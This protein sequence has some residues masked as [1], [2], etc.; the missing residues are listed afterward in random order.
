M[1]SMI[2]ILGFAWRSQLDAHRAEQAR[3]FAEQETQ[4]AR[5]VQSF[6]TD[7]FARQRP[8]VAQGR[9]ISAKDLLDDAEQQLSK[10]GAGTS[11]EV[12]AELLE[13]LANLRYDLN[14][15]DSALRHNEA[16]IAL[17]KQRFGEHSTA[18][19]LALI[20][21]SDTLWWLGRISES[22]AQCDQGL[23]VLREAKDERDE[24]LEQ[25]HSLALIACADSFRSADQY[26]RTRALQDEA[27]RRLGQSTKPAPEV[28]LGLLRSRAKL[29]Q[30]SF[31]FAASID[32]NSQL[33]ER[34][35]ADP[36]SAP[37]DIATLYHGRGATH[38]AQG[39]ASSAAHDFRVA[40]NSHL[41]TFGANA[42]LVASTRRMLALSLADLGK[43]DD[44]KHEMDTVLATARAHFE[45]ASA[46]F[47]QAVNAS[48]QLM[49]AQAS[50]A[51][52]QDPA[53]RLQSA[54]ELFR[55][56]LRVNEKSYGAS[57]GLSQQIRLNLLDIALKTKDVSEAEAQAQSFARINAA[58]QLKPELE[59]KWR[60]LLLR[61]ARQQAQVPRMIAA[62]AEVRA[63][64]MRAPKSA[65]ELGAA[66]YELA[67]AARFLGDQ[68]ALHSAQSELAA[69]LKT[70]TFDT[71][72][73]R[74][75]Q[76][77]WAEV[78]G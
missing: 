56:G 54:G 77:F 33:I 19:G 39:D 76:G 49:L 78:S 46:D 27:E 28:E 55:E 64:I 37:S 13:T 35:E 43:V 18:Y 25:A 50:S 22:L 12:R 9:N 24:A 71:Q 5:A 51:Q 53:T 34:L 73:R 66:W 20:E 3:A 7:L 41:R 17:A 40:L 58:I 4:R 16:S 45:P 65:F 63:A 8:D 6:L 26:Q 52:T 59:L 57:H 14:D 67:L 10:D 1:L 31:D 74:T 75:V 15:F 68:D 36:N 72:R 48:A 70:M 11:A 60:R 30:V 42:V 61:M 38:F 29:A 47:V 21:R 44:A 2:A 32:L 62:S 23:N 69:L